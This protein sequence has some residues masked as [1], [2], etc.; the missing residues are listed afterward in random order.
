M[1]DRESYSAP[2]ALWV[3][4]MRATRPSSPSRT[5]ATKI[6][7]AANAKYLLAPALSPAL[8]ALCA[9]MELMME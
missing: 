8:I 1:S 9:L 5:M 3:L 2:N 4:V 7:I 6:A